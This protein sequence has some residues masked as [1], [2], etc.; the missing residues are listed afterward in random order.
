MTVREVERYWVGFDE[1]EA[2][3]D[4]KDWG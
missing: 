3:Q 4:F 2:A 1:N